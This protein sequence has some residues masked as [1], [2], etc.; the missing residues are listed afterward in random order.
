MARSFVRTAFTA[1]LAVAMIWSWSLQ[2]VAQSVESDA[3][4]AVQYTTQIQRS[5]M[6][7]EDGRRQAP[8]DR[9]DPQYVVDTVGIDPA[10]LYAFVRDNVAW[11]PYRGRLRGPV[12]VLMDRTANS[13]DMSLLLADLL[14]RAGHQVRLAH[15]TLED[16]TVDAI[17][18]FLEETSDVAIVPG[19]SNE[20]VQSIAG[21]TPSA[22]QE[23]R[24]VVLSGPLGSVRS[25]APG[26][27]RLAQSMG[28]SDGGSMFSPMNGSGSMFETLSGSPAPTAATA[29]EA[30]DLYELDK[31]A[32]QE[33]LA[34]AAGDNARIASELDIRVVDQSSRLL[35]MFEPDEAAQHD[36]EQARARSQLAD[37]WWVQVQQGAD[38]VSYDPLTRDAGQ[39]YAAP[40]ETMKPEQI[41]AEMTHRVDLRVVAERLVGGKLE[42][43]V[44]FDHDL[45]PWQLIGKRISLRHLPLLWPSEWAAVTPDDVQE[46]LFAALYTQKEW[47][48]GLV[49]GDQAF[50]QSSVLDTGATNPNPQ[51]QS[52]PFLQ[53][54]F[55]VAGKVGRIVDLFDQV[56]DEADAVNG[57]TADTPAA[58]APREAGELTAEWIEYTISVPGEKPKTIRREIFDILGPAMRR[59]GDYSGLR[60]DEDKRLTRAAGQMTETDIVILPSW[61]A[62][63]F[64]ADMAAGLALANKPVLDE[65][66][67]DPF[68]KAPTNSIELFSKM[69]G[70]AGPAYLYSS[71]RSG[72][73]ATRGKVFVDRPQV[74]AQHSILASVGPG[75]LAGQTAIDVVE[76]GV[77][78]D[79]FEKR[80]F[81]HRLLQG[82]ADTN[83]EA[84]ALPRVGQNVGEAFREAAQSGWT[85]LMPGEGEQLAALGLDADLT[86]RLMGELDAGMMVISPSSASRPTEMAGWWRVDP[87]SGAT[88]G[89]GNRGWGA[90]L[91]EFAFV[92]LVQAMLA[93]IA[94]MASTAASAAME[95]ELHRGS[96][97][98]GRKQVQ[99]WASTCVKQAILETLT[100]MSTSYLSDNFIHGAKPP[101]WTDRAKGST[102][103]HPSTSNNHPPPHTNPPH[104]SN[105]PHN[106]TPP[107]NNNP[108]SNKN[109][110]NDHDPPPPP[111][112]T[113]RSPEDGNTS[114]TRKNNN[115]DNR[116]KDGDTIVWDNERKPRHQPETTDSG[117]N[118]QSS[119]TAGQEGPTTKRSPGNDGPDTVRNPSRAP[120]SDATPTNPLPPKPNYDDDFASKSPRDPAT[121]RNP[122]SESPD[123]VRN[124]SH[125]PDSDAASTTRPGPKPD[126][127]DD[128]ASNP[129]PG[130]KPDYDDDFAST[131]P[132]T[133]PNPSRVPDSDAA[134]TT[135]P[136]PKP[137]YNDDFASASPKTTPQPSRMPDSDAVPTNRQ[138]PHQ[139]SAPPT[140]RSPGSDAPDTVR[141]PSHSP[142]T[143]R[144]PSSPPETGRNPGHAP[145]SDAASTKPQT[146]KPNYDDD[147]ASK[148]PRDPAT[149]PNPGRAPDSDAASTTRPGPKPNY[150]DDFASSPPHEPKTVPNP[151][152]APDSD[153][154]PTKRSPSF[155]DPDRVPNSSRP[156]ESDV[157]STRRPP[158]QPLP[159]QPGDTTPP[160]RRSPGNDAPDTAHNPSHAPDTV[161]NPSHTPDTVR[162]PSSSPETGRNPGRAP[163]SDALP[164]QRQQPKPTT[165]TEGPATKRGVGPQT[166][167]GL[168][169]DG[170]AHPSTTGHQPSDLAQ[171]GPA[172]K[173]G[174]GPEA[175]PGIGPDVP[176]RHTP[177]HNPGT[178]D[179]VP[180][181]QHGPSDLGHADTQPQPMQPSNANPQNAQ[182]NPRPT[183][184]TPAEKVDAVRQHSDDYIAAHNREAAAAQRMI[185][186]PSLEN[187]QAYHDAVLAADR[188]RKTEAGEWRKVGGDGFPPSYND[189][190]RQPLPD[191]TKVPVLPGTEITQDMPARPPVHNP[192]TADT[193]LAQGRTQP[194]DRS[195]TVPQQ[196]QSGGNSDTVPQQR[197]TSPMDR[198]PTVPQQQ[199]GRS[200]L[201]NA[202][203]QPQQRQPSNGEQPTAQGN[204]RPVPGTHAEKVDAVRQQTNDYIAAHNREVT[205]A[206]QMIDNPSLENRQAYHDAVL[207]ADRAR[208]AEAGQWG[209]LGGDGLPPS[210][211]DSQRQPLPDVSRVP[212]LPGTEITQEMPAQPLPRTPGTADTV[213]KQGRTQP[214]DRSP[215]VPQ[216]QARSEGTADTA[217]RQSQTQPMDRSPTVPQE[218][219]NPGKPQSEA[220]IAQA[221]KPFS[222]ARAAASDRLQSA[223]ERFEADRSPE[224]LRSLDQANKDYARAYDQ[225]L[226][227]YDRAGGTGLAPAGQLPD[228][229]PR[230]PTIP[231]IAPAPASQ[232]STGTNS[233]LAMGLGALAGVIRKGP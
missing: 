135:R 17:W 198:S 53:I 119:S 165:T 108:N 11:V 21:A 47:M 91:V 31:A 86:S 206:Q 205:A 170:P 163:D 103:P 213:L 2:A 208:K 202:D 218:A 122:G 23:Q 133:T 42:E 8:R 93:Q 28:A 45:E 70:M 114:T 137:D 179:T 231:G 126:Y 203:T 196:A 153:A 75:E 68:G 140:Q 52:N 106:N 30:A 221:I 212:V 12:G 6:A 128:F 9:W 59:S 26:P 40:A 107:N 226:D 73:A 190:Q 157:A 50:Q 79:P 230:V 20:T 97:E 98:E 49:V 164:T 57:E 229:R 184:R 3:T 204:P 55:P 222:D 80:P 109:T 132:K 201:G 61:P 178:A 199:H 121:P 24:P 54:A 127:N 18:S 19:V 85:V 117:P 124:P 220:E 83:A 1:T 39:S 56:L 217:L 37:H 78:V 211:N 7:I 25:D 115:D 62:R 77:G 227:A 169:P 149:Q 92:L 223:R 194:M 112:P 102:H 29:D 129:R 113:K 15:A 228:A 118:R 95:G 159:K 151:S 216:Q 14:A 168:G 48:P 84:L 41:S 180:Q 72:V 210:Y 209:R 123:T 158:P 111:P 214:M 36:Y 160:T 177:S 58:G 43:Q 99:Q 141:N 195:P 82:V 139:D 101:T 215:T 150:D 27:E 192:G 232:A 32:A 174:V 5:L 152:R 207:A 65:F 187:R 186:N 219:R 125:A 138:Q 120:D 38:W 156:P 76:N 154:S 182:A 197:Q 176:G 89:M 233:T 33:T 172:T 60:I 144:N 71:L 145:D 90:A 173:P 74:V 94:C 16:T 136:G 131:S 171:S 224:N 175:K 44:V 110:H 225:E 148:S 134:S 167:P 155:E 4:R 22:T 181:R 67:R 69:S 105:P 87:V 166:K 147:F 161:R 162:N 143:V 64:L 81:L 189:S 51:P 88:L 193:V 96:A 46:K 66:T 185:D 63:E 146:P 116:I 100:G 13:L 10:G 200:D 142:D 35:A 183:P 34:N 104:D 191:V 188:A 130:P